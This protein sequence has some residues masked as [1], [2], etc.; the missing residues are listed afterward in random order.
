[1]TKTRL[2]RCWPHISIN[3]SQ[4]LAEND[5]LD[6]RLLTRTRIEVKLLG[7]W[8]AL[9]AAL[10]AFLSL[11]GEMREGELT[12]F[13]TWVLVALR[14]VNS[15]HNAIG[16]QWLT[17][18]M[19]DI[20][21]LGSFTVLFLITVVAVSMLFMHGK[22][23]QAGVLAAGVVLA[24]VSGELLKLFYGRMRPSF[25]VYGD[26]PTSLSFP[27]G[28]STVATATYFLLA[29]IVAG[30]EVR[31]AAKVLVFAMAALLAIAIGVSRVYLGV[32]WPSDVIAGWCLGGFWALAASL[33]LFGS[34]ARAR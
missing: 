28:H 4:A 11:A 18:G 5:G 21:A 33:V 34:S 19:R 8:T 3:A 16:P 1:M 30:L 27:S 22:N 14:H 17:G 24:Q 15:P 12:A 2:E 23:R 25:A 31:I 6:F 13:D 20:T 10:W 29:L 9:V 7:L 26:L 32:H